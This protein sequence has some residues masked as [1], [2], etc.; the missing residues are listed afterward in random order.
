MVCCRAGDLILWDSRTVHCNTPCLDH[1]AP[2]T[3]QPFKDL[4]RAV[5]YV[6]MT[7]KRWAT[8]AV[9]AERRRAV[10]GLVGTT[11]WPH[12]FYPIAANGELGNVGVRLRLIASNLEGDHRTEA[13]DMFE[14]ASKAEASGDF[15]LAIRTYK[16]AHHLWPELDSNDDLTYPGLPKDVVAEARRAGVDEDVIAGRAVNARPDHI[17]EAVW[18]MIT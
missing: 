18:Q 11:H 6:C 9:L 1:P 5:C 7:P 8:N 15:D 4:I 16:R 14:S 10:V 13:V 2:E 17:S 12:E 3:G